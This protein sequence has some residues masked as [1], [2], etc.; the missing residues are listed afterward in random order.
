MKKVTLHFLEVWPK[1]YDLFSLE[2]KKVNTIE[3]L[4]TTGRTYKDYEN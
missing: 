3:K 4:S 2:G 1:A